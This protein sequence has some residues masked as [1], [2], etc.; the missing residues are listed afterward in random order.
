MNVRVVRQA[1]SQESLFSIMSAWCQGGAGRKG[2]RIRI[3]S[4]FATGGAVRAMS[5]L[6]DVF[7][8]DGNAVEIVFGVDRNGT[9][10]DAVARLFAIHEAYPQQVSACVFEAPSSVAIF[11]PKLY[12]YSEGREL[13]SAVIGSANLTMGG[14]ANNFESLLLYESLRANDREA[15][16]L[17]AIWSTFARPAPPLLPE[18]CT[19]LSQDIVGRLL[20]RLPERSPIA[21]TERRKDIV[22]LW[23]PLSTVPLPRST[24]P[25]RRSGTMRRPRQRRTGRFLLMDILQETRRTQMQ[26]PLRV[27]EDFFGVPR[28]TAA[29]IEVSIMTGTGLSQPITRT[30]VISQGAEG[31]RLMRRLEM[32]TIEGLPRPLIVVFV[33]LGVGRF[34]YR[35]IGRSAVRF[36]AVDRTLARSG[37]QGGAQRRYYIGQMGDAVWRALNIQVLS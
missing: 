36:Q 3:L 23:R 33:R 30:L 14:L 19:P 37:Q 25:P 28:R 2:C 18:F 9:D 6:I 21:A 16:E 7:L 24:A 10:R 13:R 15:R 20:A 4:A 26:I 12:L 32:P 8:A 29:D 27:V 17:E 22:E 35:L 5:P 31:R 34:T 11:H 1:V